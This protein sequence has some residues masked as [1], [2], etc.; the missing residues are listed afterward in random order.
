MGCSLENA[1]T[2]LARRRAGGHRG[3]RPGNRTRRCDRPCF[4][5]AA[6][7]RPGARA[8]DER[9]IRYSRL[10]ASL[11]LSLAGDHMYPIR[12]DFCL[13]GRVVPRPQ[14]RRA[15]C[16]AGRSESHLRLRHGRAT[17]SPARGSGPMRGPARRPATG[18]TCPDLCK[19]QS[20]RDTNPGFKKRALLAG[21]Y[22]SGPLVPLSYA[23]LGWI[24]R[25]ARAL[26]RRPVSRIGIKGNEGRAGKIC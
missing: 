6:G 15:S 13:L 7:E 26:P 17:P 4:C 25:L 11:D 16:P 24:R 21:L 22:E 9:P 20:I 18:K 12:S 10:F 14:D 5:R 8:V 19:G 3:P 23:S 1:A 2:T